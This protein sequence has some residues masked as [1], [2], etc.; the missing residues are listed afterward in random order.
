MPGTPTHLRLCTALI[1]ITAASTARA[2]PPY[3]S[4][5]PEPTDDRHYEIYFFAN[6][7]QARDGDS[8]AAGL[9]FNYGAGPDLQLTAVFP[10]EYD[11]PDGEASTSGLGNIEL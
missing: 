6:G 11:N 8:A 5:D 10:V 4:D 9:D 1:L 2:G 7:S 3:Q